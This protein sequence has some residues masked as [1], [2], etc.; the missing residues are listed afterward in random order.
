VLEIIEVDVTVNKLKDRILAEIYH[1]ESRKNLIRYTRKAFQMLPQ[2]ERPR[3]LDLGCGSGLPTLELARLSNGEITGVDIN[4]ASLDKLTKKAKDTGLADRVKVIN[5]SVK[6]M[7]FPDESFDIIWAEGVI[8]IIGFEKGLKQWRRFLKPEGFLVVHDDVGD[9]N[10]KRELISK[11]GYQVI[12]IFIISKDIWWTEYYCPLEKHI[13]EVREKY[14][15]D[16]E[17]LAILD[18]EQQEIDHFQSD[19]GSKGS[20]FFVMQK[21]S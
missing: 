5:C 20:A 7:K 12:D 6:E 3:I 17:I 8:W 16:Q 4:Q 9:I 2:L 15:D 14:K 21:S 10:E 1:G 13:Q 19:L 18:E 11:N